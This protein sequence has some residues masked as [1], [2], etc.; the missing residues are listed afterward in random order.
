MTTAPATASKQGTE[1]IRDV[2]HGSVLIVGAGVSG[3]GAAHHL[4]DRFPDRT[5]VILDA[6]A[7]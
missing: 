2:G 6:L 7:S 5:F 4:R 1:D 3:I